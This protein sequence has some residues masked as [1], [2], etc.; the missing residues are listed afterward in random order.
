[1]TFLLMYRW[2]PLDMPRW[3]GKPDA[4]RT[5]TG[6]IRIALR[7]ELAVPLQVIEIRVSKLPC[8]EDLTSYIHH[9]L[10]HIKC[11]AVLYSFSPF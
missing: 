5:E 10:S 1:M 2:L 11:F 7:Y 3:P 4:E 6:A 8:H 9:L